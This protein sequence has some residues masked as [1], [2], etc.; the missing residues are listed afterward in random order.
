MMRRLVL[1]ALASA[2]VRGLAKL[3]LVALQPT[4]LD[5]IHTQ[6]F[7]IAYVP[8]NALT[9]G[10][11]RFRAQP[12][13]KQLGPA[14]RRAGPLNEMLLYTNKAQA[15]RFVEGL[16]NKGANPDSYYVFPIPA[17]QSYDKAFEQSK[18]H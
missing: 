2:P 13:T 18:R 8:P 4:T 12:V 9:E 7:G 11:P 1:A 15:D 5:P 14:L 16:I 6:S 3:T 10:H 17:G